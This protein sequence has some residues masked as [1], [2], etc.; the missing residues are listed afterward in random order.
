MALEKLSAS[1]KALAQDREPLSNTI[2]AAITS[3]L[4]VMAKDPNRKDIEI[5]DEPDSDEETDAKAGSS[6]LN[7]R[8]NIN[9]V[10][11]VREYLETFLSGKSHEVWSCS[12]ILKIP[13]DAF[14]PSGYLE[15]DFCEGVATH[16][17]K[18]V[19]EKGLNDLLDQAC[20]HKR[21]KK[22][23]SS[24]LNSL[25]STENDCRSYPKGFTVSMSYGTSSLKLEVTV[26]LVRSVVR[27]RELRAD[28][29]TEYLASGEWR[30]KAG[31]YAIQGNAAYFVDG[32]DG[33]ITNVVGLPIVDVANIL[34]K[35]GIF[36]S[37]L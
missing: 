23:K 19:K 14:H 3:D 4:V 28:E 37:A 12:V 32:V 2:K 20:N 22:S 31:G 30:Q 24:P 1:L 15:K 8:R 33:S 34:R 9:P 16:I 36:E 5:L 6:S 25:E 35:Y 11:R 26:L 13:R 10:D 17:P 21:P 29:V 7:N 18:H 27:F